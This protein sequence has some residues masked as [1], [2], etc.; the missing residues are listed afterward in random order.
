MVCISGFVEKKVLFR[1][2]LLLHTKKR[3]IWPRVAHAAMDL[4]CFYRRR[5]LLERDIFFVLKVSM[6]KHLRPNLQATLL[7]VREL[8]LV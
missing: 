1:Q 2:L 5:L 8:P 7:S 4:V 3:L 6:F